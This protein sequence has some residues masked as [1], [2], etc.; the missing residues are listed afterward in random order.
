M[1]VALGHHF[2]EL[3]DLG[4]PAVTRIVCKVT[5]KVTEHD[6]NDNTIYLPVCL[7]KLCK[8]QG[9]ACHTTSKGSYRIKWVCEGPPQNNIVAWVT[10]QHF[11]VREFPR[12]KVKKSV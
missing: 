11:W 8:G 10:Y 3:E 5:G 9:W 1:V 12:P 2:T 4:K 6:K 7:Q